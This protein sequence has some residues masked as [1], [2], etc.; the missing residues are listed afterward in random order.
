[1]EKFKYK[2]KNPEGKLIEGLVEARDIKQAAQTLRE[3]RLLVIDLRPYKAKV[4]ILASIPLFQRVSRDDVVNFTRQLATMMTAGLQLTDA[5][6]LLES[7][8]K[9]AMRR[10]LTSVHKDIEGGESLWSS[11]SKHPHVFS[12]FFINMVS[13]GDESGKLTHMF[14]Y[15]ADYLERQY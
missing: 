15:L 7:Q 2:A 13:A 3:N 4:D 12:D 8:A 6:S 5:L 9:P 11:L 14:S 1:M 10:V